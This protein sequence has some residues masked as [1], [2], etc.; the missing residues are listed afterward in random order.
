M[1]RLKPRLAMIAAGLA[2]AAT[3]TGVGAA[4]SMAGPPSPA[5]VVQTANG[6]VR[7]VV[8]DSYRVFNGIPYAEPPVGQLR[9]QP[10]QPAA[11]WAGV[12]DA[13]QPGSGA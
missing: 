12:R 9:W 13:T 2:L 7:G 4:A 5:Q 11:A 3:V 8:S 1:L 6:S 10:P